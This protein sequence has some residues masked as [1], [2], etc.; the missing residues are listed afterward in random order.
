MVNYIIIIND[1]KFDVIASFL[2]KSDRLR[3]HIGR[4]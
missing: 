2:I 1:V 4:I 3:K